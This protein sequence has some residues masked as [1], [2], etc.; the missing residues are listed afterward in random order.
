MFSLQPN[1]SLCDLCSLNKAITKLAKPRTS[2]AATPLPP[3]LLQ[4]NIINSA[5]GVK[6]GAMWD[7]CST[8]DYITFSKAEELGVAR[9]GCGAHCGRDWKYRGNNYY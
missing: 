7:L 3:V 8:D 6:L 1:Q 2:V 4:T 9:Q 5:N